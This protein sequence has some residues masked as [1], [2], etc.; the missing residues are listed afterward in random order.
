MT[1]IVS[2]VFLLPFTSLEMTQT[3]ESIPILSQKKEFL[4]EKP[5]K[6]EVESYIKF[7]IVLTRNSF[8]FFRNL[9]AL[10]FY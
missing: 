9:V 3:S 7:R 4:K 8:I 10:F 2:N 6:P 1:T 5:P